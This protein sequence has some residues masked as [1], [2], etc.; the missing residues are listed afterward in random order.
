MEDVDCHFSKRWFAAQKQN[1]PLAN[2]YVAE[3]K[4]S[5]QKPHFVATQLRGITTRASREAQ[6]AG[7]G[8]WVQNFMDEMEA[9]RMA[10]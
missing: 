2:F 5:P 8:Q 9:R 10:R 6:P 1:W 4:S 7:T 3:T